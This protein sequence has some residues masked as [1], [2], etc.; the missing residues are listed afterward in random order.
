[1]YNYGM[2]PLVYSERDAE[3][4]TNCGWTRKGSNVC[5]YQN[6]FQRR[7]ESKRLPYYTFTFTYTHHRPDDRVYFS[8]CYPYTYTNVLSHLKSLQVWAEVSRASFA[9]KTPHLSFFGLHLSPFAMKSLI[10]I[11]VQ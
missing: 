3:D 2:Q 10:Y 6:F 9:A 8:Y 11:F 1:M 4:G 5:Y 7:A